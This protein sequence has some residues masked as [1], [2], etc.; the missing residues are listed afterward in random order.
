MKT[1]WM[2]PHRNPLSNEVGWAR[3]DT[4]ELSFHCSRG[5]ITKKGNGWFFKK[6]VSPCYFICLRFCWHKM[7]PSGLNGAE[8][9]AIPDFHVTM[10]TFP[11]IDEFWY[12]AMPKAIFP[13]NF[14]FSIPD[15]HAASPWVTDFVTERR[16]IYKLIVPPTWS[17]FSHVVTE[18]PKLVFGANLICIKPKS[19]I[20]IPTP[21]TDF[22]LQLN[23]NSTCFN[24]FRHQINSRSKLHLIA[25]NPASLTVT[26]LNNRR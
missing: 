9:S 2:E 21:S 1:T 11:K 6:F 20:P 7:I 14:R 17:N 19:S 25:Q 10:A 5:N 8:K 23:S 24:D 12:I 18:C 3:I 22:N 16:A 26:V 4:V 13:E 15:G